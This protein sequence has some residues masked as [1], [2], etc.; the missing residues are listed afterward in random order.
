MTISQRKAYGW[1]NKKQESFV[2]WKIKILGFLE[3]YHISRERRSNNIL[4]TYMHRLAEAD[5]DIFCSNL[6]LLCF[7]KS[8]QHEDLQLRTLSRK[9]VID[10]KKNSCNQHDWCKNSPSG[11]CRPFCWEDFEVLVIVKVGNC[12][13]IGSW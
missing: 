10:R 12:S 8:M 11:S 6:L 5:Q 1:V 4:L 3:R 7:N 9:N 13:V 2:K